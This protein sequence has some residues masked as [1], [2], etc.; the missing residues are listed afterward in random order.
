MNVKS[1][2]VSS[3]EHVWNAVYYNNKWLNL[4]LTWDDPVYDDGKNYLNHDYFLITTT[5]LLEI[6]K[7]QHDINYYHYPELKE[8]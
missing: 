7:T 8:A 4:D 6:E 1:Y 3:D 5:K 2:R